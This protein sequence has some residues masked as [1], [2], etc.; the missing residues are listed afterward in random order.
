MGEPDLKTDGDP[1]GSEDKKIFIDENEWLEKER[2]L[3]ELEGYK[4]GVEDSE[5]RLGQQHPETQQTPQ[6]D[7]PPKEPE[8]QFHSEEDLQKALAEG[9][10]VSYHKM[11]QHNLDTK[12]E[13]RD[14][15]LRTKEIDPIRKTGMDAISDLSGAVSQP[16]MPH[17]DIPEVKATYNQRLQALKGTGQPVTAE[18]HK[19][20]YDWAV[21]ENI[22][23]VQDKIQQG[24][25]R[26][27]QEIQANTPTDSSGRNTGDDS[28]KVPAINEFFEPAAIQKLQQKYPGMSPEAAADREF[29]RHG[30]YAEYYKKYYG[31]KGED[32]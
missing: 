2:K 11:S 4:K 26:E 14:W 13:Q 15:N 27:Q 18:V 20:V 6:Q 3:A 12:L 25:L 17:L 9:D 8:F 29:A 1:S 24:F 19:G 22:A 7:P 16:K 28:I 23:K 30:G 10:L 31:P 32:K 5:L 21:G